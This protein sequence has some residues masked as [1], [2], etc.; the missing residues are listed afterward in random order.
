MLGE[1]LAVSAI[2]ILGAGVVTVT[3]A[4]KELKNSRIKVAMADRLRVT[5]AP[6]W[7]SRPHKN[8]R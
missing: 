4:A 3:L 2:L 7:H 6:F 8:A 1:Q 5:H